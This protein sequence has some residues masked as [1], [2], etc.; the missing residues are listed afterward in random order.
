MAIVM[1]EEAFGNLTDEQI[2]TLADM[3]NG[4]KEEETHDNQ[5]LLKEGIE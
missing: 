3:L 5:D 4:R 2:Q 1:N